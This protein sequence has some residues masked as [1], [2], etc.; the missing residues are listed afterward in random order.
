MAK[1][2]VREAKEDKGACLKQVHKQTASNAVEKCGCQC[3]ADCKCGC[4]N[5]HIC[6]CCEPGE[7]VKG[8]Y[9]CPGDM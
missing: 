5:P 8:D 9:D 1:E 6:D 4:C 3:E 7:C 2:S